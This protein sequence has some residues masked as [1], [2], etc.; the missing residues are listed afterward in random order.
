M[1]TPADLLFTTSKRFVLQPQRPFCQKLRFP[2]LPI[3]YLLHQGSN[4]VFKR[5]NPVEVKVELSQGSRQDF[6]LQSR[7]YISK[8]IQGFVGFVREI[9]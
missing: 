5:D 9:L 1:R 7:L 3:F 2:L 8:E 6:D 4:W